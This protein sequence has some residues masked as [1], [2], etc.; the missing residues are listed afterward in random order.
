MR[1]A[2]KDSVSHLIGAMQA[3]G[4]GKWIS[5]IRVNK[6]T[7]YLKN[8]EGSTYFCSAEEAHRAYVTAIKEL[9]NQR[10]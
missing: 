2:R 7:I 5:R 3:G 1:K 6:Q 8:S 10:S 9:A 4:R